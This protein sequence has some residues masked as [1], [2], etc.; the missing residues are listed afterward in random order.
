MKNGYAKV[1]N[2]IWHG[3][4]MAMKH[5]VSSV[6]FWGLEKPRQPGCSQT[7]ALSWLEKRVTADTVCGCR[8]VVSV[9]A[10]RYNTVCVYKYVSDF[11]GV[12]MMESVFATVFQN[13]FP[14][15]GAHFLLW[16][17]L[18]Y[19]YKTHLDLK[20]QANIVWVHRVGLIFMVNEA[21]PSC[22]S[23][24]HHR[25]ESQLLGFLACGNL[26]ITIYSTGTLFKVKS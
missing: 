18:H 11:R 7:P 5:L 12:Q 8:C 1:N 10:L 15:V 3:R 9:Y 2:L 23:A 13:Y 26:P 6:S 14:W 25:L 21:A 17:L 22:L 4:I 24:C 16:K 19:Q 20:L